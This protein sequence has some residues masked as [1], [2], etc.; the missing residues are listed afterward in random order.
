MRW[1][2]IVKHGLTLA[3]G[4]DWKNN[5]VVFPRSR[6]FL[7]PCRFDVKRFRGF[8]VAGNC[9]TKSFKPV[10]GVHYWLVLLVRCLSSTS[11]LRTYLARHCIDRY[12]FFYNY[13]CDTSSFL[14]TTLQLL[15]LLSILQNFFVHSSYLFHE[16]I[17]SEKEN[18]LSIRVSNILF[19]Y[20]FIVV[21]FCQAT[22]T[23]TSFLRSL[24]RSK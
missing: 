4:N 14:I 13:L 16:E 8:A 22:A 18:W 24:G 3:R 1:T 6:S 20:E 23:F 5:I 17:D 21:T 11:K 12:S 2:V 19:R 9:H 7:H 10:C 15:L